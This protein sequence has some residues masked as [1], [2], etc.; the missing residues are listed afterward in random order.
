VGGPAVWYTDPLGRRASPARFANSITQRIAPVTQ[1][2]GIDF[3]GP[4][5]GD[6]RTYD[7]PGVRSPN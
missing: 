1:E 4:Y 3:D 2:I 7:G 5:I 6:G